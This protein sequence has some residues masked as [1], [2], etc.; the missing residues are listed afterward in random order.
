MK[1][2]IE[3]IDENYRYWNN[4]N[5]LAIE[6][7]P[8]EEYLDPLKIIEMTKKED[9][10]FLSLVDDNNFVGFMVIKTF[11]ILTYL[12]FLAIDKQYQSQG[13]GTQAIQLLKK[14]YPNKIHTVDLEMI[15][16]LANNKEQRIKRKNFYLRN[17]YKETGLYL[18]YLNVEYEVLCTD[19]NFDMNMFKEMM[20]S[21]NIEGFYPKYFYNDNN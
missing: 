15:N 6:S 5:L 20:E 17:G 11:N 9:L 7:F 2:K 8:S 19:D 12:F 14:K 18:S 3:K 13:Y 4:V 16:D 1:L 10:E 21:F